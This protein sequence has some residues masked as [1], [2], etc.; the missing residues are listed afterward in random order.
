M[1]GGRCFKFI[2]E[3]RVVWDTLQDLFKLRLENSSLPFPPNT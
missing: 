1:N 3:A 2:D